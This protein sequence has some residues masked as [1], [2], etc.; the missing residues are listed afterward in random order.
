MRARMEVYLETIKFFSAFVTLFTK[1]CLGA[2]SVSYFK[3]DDVNTDL[4]HGNR[5][6]AKF[7]LLQ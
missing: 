4:G 3:L 7:A 5:S 2:L 6:R 1:F